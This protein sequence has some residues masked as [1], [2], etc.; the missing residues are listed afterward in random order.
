MSMNFKRLLY[1]PFGKMVLSILLGIGLASLFHKVCKDKD[2][3]TFN[4]PVIKDMDG[5]TY[6]HGEQCYKYEFIPAPC[7]AM[8]SIVA[9]S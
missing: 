5:K 7:D 4:G 6:Q 3:I 1:T 9:L 8:K 2:C